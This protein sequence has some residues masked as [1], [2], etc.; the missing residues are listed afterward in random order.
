MPP[1][2]AKGENTRAPKRATP[3]KKRTT[4]ANN[5]GGS[6]GKGNST[7][8]GSST[9]NGTSG[10]VDITKTPIKNNNS[11]V[12]G[13]G[14]PSKNEETITPKRDE[15]IDNNNN[16][17]NNNNNIG[18]NT[19]NKNIDIDSTYLDPPRDKNRYKYRIEI[20][21]MMFVSGETNDPPERTTDL[22][23]DIV[24]DQVVSLLL[25]AQR[26]T[27]S[28]GQRAILPED[29]IFLIRH[30]K[31]KVN[32]L[33]TYLSWKDVRKNAK[34]QENGDI[35][36][37]GGSG[38]LLDDA[39]GGIGGSGG[40]DNKL[41]AA[42][43]KKSLKLPWEL[44]FMFTEQPLSGGINGN[45][46]DE[47]IDEEERDAVLAQIKRLRQNDERTKNMTQQEYVHWSEC[48]Q[49]SFTFRK[50]KR[51]REWCGISQVTESRPN[52]DVIDILGFLTFE[53]VCSIT[54]EALKVKSSMDSL[55][56]E[57]DS[58][59]YIFMEPSNDNKPISVEHIQEAWR[60]LQEVPM[61]KQALYNFRGGR[62]LRNVRLI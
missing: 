10:G 29:L 27:Q 49:A 26:T 15:E 19:N 22:I 35:G 5:K 60:R 59:R 12:N 4:K 40:V 30:D 48:R 1:A 14:T 51:F 25:Q 24:R 38:D 7:T 36:A 46:D 2:K 57:R 20:Q 43:Q 50:S 31:A 58:H 42:K 44:E 16:N 41:L 21:Q 17:N 52:D 53:M 56:D 33:R 28:R 6:T 62:I 23:E 54:E 11:G 9:S 34:D 37:G 55:L 18:N 61:S 45:I 8:G 3:A 39:S 47:K 32:R 13:N